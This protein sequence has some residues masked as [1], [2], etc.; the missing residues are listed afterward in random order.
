VQPKGILAIAVGYGAGIYF[1][2]AAW[3]K[4]SLMR[5]ASR[6]PSVRGRIIESTLFKNA[7]GKTHFRVRYE[8][9]VGERIE[10]D[11]ARLCGD[12]FWNNEAQAAFVAR[13][14]PGQEVEVYFSP[15]D[16]RQNCL[17]RTD[18]SGITAMWVIAVGGVTLAS[19]LVALLFWRRT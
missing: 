6:W 16:S 1:S 10:S 9:V 5:A 12:W 3:K 8:F 15:R 11:T 2:I 7:Q 13:F 14:S 19:I 18:R 17:D 4:S